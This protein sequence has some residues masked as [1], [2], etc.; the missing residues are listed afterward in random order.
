MLCLIAAAAVVRRMVALARS[1]QNA[2]AQLAGLDAAFAKKRVL[3][4]IHII[5]GLI[6]VTLIP[7]Q[8]SSSFRRRHL[9]AHRWTGRVVIIVGFIIG[10]SA[11]PMSRE[12]IGGRL[13][14]SAIAFFDALFLG[15]LM[16]AFIHIR[17]REIT[18]HREWMIRAMS[19]ALGV[20]TV[21]PIMGIFFATGPLTG[22]APRQFFGIAFWIGFSLTYIAAE[23]WIR[24]TKSSALVASFLNT[25]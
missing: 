8:F 24:C 25:K 14:L 21:R 12:P 1:P 17:R 16:R 23:L 19:I 22:L 20:A 3:T 2:P 6:L 13:E 7:L 11:I 4:L 9:R 5:P 10:V 15:T 18:L